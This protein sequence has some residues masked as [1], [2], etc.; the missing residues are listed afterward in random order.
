MFSVE[1]LTF[2][3]FPSRMATASPGD[4]QN[5]G[6]QA[7]LFFLKIAILLIAAGIAALCAGGLWILIGFKLAPLAIVAWIVLMAEV[8]ALIPCMALAFN[9]YDP[10]AD[11]PV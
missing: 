9:R 7:V 4:L 5:F 2:L 6:R 1:N 3:L 11:T 8:A 10:S